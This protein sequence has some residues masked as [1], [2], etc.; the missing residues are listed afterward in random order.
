VYVQYLNYST[1]RTEEFTGIDRV[2]FD[3][4]IGDDELDASGLNG[5]PLEFVGGAGDD[6]VLVGS[7]SAT[8]LSILDGGVGNDRIEVA[9][10][11]RFRILGGLGDDEIEA[12]TGTVTVN[13]GGG[14]DTIA[15]GAGSTATLVFDR[16]YGADTLDLSVAALVNLLDFT[17][18]SSGVAGLLSGAGST[19][20][21]G[22]GNV[23]TFN[24]AAATE[25][26][27]SQQR[28]RFTV[29]NPNT[30]AAN[31]G[32]GLVLRG[33]LG[34]DVYEI[35]ADTVSGVSADGITIDDILPP[36]AAA[37]AGD[38]TLSDGD[39]GH[40]CEIEVDDPG[41][42]YTVAPDVVI[43]DE[44]GSGARAV[45]SLDEQ[46]RVT[47]II[48]T[49]EGR[50]YTNP[51]VFLVN[52][53]STSDK[54]VFT[55]T[56]ATATL[57]RGGNGAAGD[58]RIATGGK[59]FKFVGWTDVGSIRPDEF[60]TSEIDSVTVNL[61][62]GVFTLVQ[63]IDL[64]DTF[65]VNARRM[66]QNARIVADTV[67]LTTDNG[68]QVRHAIDAVNNG[69]V[70]IRSTGNNL[71]NY[72]T[73]WAKADATVTSSAISGVTLTNA[74]DHYWFAPSVT[75]A[76]GGGSGA[77]A[78][79]TVANGEITGIT[80]LG[81]GS[82]Y[83]QSPRP[84][85]VIAPAA[86][87]QVDAMITSTNPGSGVGYG[88]GRGRVLLYAD[89]GSVVTAG[90]VFFPFDT[91]DGVPRGARTIDWLDGD[92]RY[93]STVAID[94][95]LN[96]TT[97][98]GISVGTGAEFTAVLDDDG[99]VVGFTKV[100]GGSGYTFDLPPSVDIEGLATAV[101]IV[102]GDGT[103][104]G[105]RITYPGEGYGQAPRVT[106]RPNGFGLIV[107]F[108][109]AN[110]A[111]AADGTPLNRAP[112]QAAGGRLV[113][114]AGIQIGDPS[115]PLKSDVETFVAQTIQAGGSISLL[116]KDGL[117]IGRDEA[118]DGI[119]TS[120]GNVTITTFGGALELGAPVQRVDGQGR[121]LWQDDAKTIP[122]YERD[123]EGNIVY[124]GGQI[125]VGDASVKL[126]ADDIE[127]NVPL[128][129]GLLAS[130]GR[131]IILQPV[132]V[133]AEIG[134]S[135]TRARVQAVMTAG[136]ISGFTNV[137]GGRGYLPGQPPTVVV[138]PP[139]ERAF[140]TATARA[141]AVQFVEVVF[142][143][144]NYTT[145]PVVTLIGGGIGG[146]TPANPAVVEAVVGDDG[147]I[148]GF[149]V[150]SGG[151]GYVT[152]PR[153]DVAL[154]GQQAR[155]RA[156]LADSANADPVSGRLAVSHFEII[157]AGS[158]YTVTPRIEVAAPYDF[159]L[160]A[161]EIDQFN[162]SFET[163]TI[164]RIEGEHLFHSP[165]GSFRDG[166]V[167]RAPRAGGTIDM[168]SLVSTGS[169]S[170]VGSGNTFHF[171]SAAATLSGTSISIDDNVI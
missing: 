90:E 159:T 150:T 76:G 124:E 10:G 56:A 15:T 127:V 9:G 34:D 69:D 155:V 33:G 132:K 120:G 74:G 42:G 82:G 89:K 49:R 70:T 31:G 158:N 109:L 162:D 164:G 146:A 64:F 106:I 141:G 161:D 4:G 71:L 99:R 114:V 83:F 110:P 48:V 80:V 104:E 143:G 135:G 101:A 1:S 2:L 113:A 79:A 17:E 118:V 45:A 22:A 152:A 28:D 115:K 75:F 58:Y 94:D 88:D 29:T 165:E 163:V 171:D 151:S 20:A 87:I 85:V 168:N 11:G 18:S 51:Q 153:V 52:P 149:T 77:R 47:R 119:I 169:V 32:R 160:D 129:D 103:I 108:D 25:I 107:D 68:F 59:D 24:L 117:R 65:T 16:Q 57:D 36:L 81:G 46:G 39:C 102:A 73:S 53:A 167:L 23:V 14:S 170:I 96:A 131:E 166:L 6:T 8:Q 144:T 92:F 66:E 93:R 41:L 105:L 142:G 30:R 121:L 116:E 133:D 147:S 78:R 145:A 7:G 157:Q 43:V 55:S 67:S 111:L 139:G 122:I 61:P 123:A 112:R 13:G 63:S 138:A 60:D 62:L 134:L 37:T 154:P 54:L 27:G 72:A 38:V 125:R 130:T 26:R 5:L 136:G 128:N 95:L 148:I 19:I 100:S 35:I 97:H 44:T 40:I 3:G 86:S 84:Q 140:G 98:P 91:R 50:G 156:V 126:T 21:A 137:W 12:G